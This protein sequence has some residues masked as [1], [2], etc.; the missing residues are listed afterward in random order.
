MTALVGSGH[1]SI[2]QLVTEIG[3]LL[4]ESLG[5]KQSFAGNMPN[6]RFYQDP[7]FGVCLIESSLRLQL[8]RF[9][10]GGFQ[11]SKRR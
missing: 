6:D 2:G 10:S 8:S 11:R 9:P 5:T 1:S 3:R 4:P 7:T